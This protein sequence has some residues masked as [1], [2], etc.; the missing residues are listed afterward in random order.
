MHDPRTRTALVGLVLALPPLMVAAA[1]RGPSARAAAPPVLAVE[2][3]LVAGLAVA[4]RERVRLRAAPAGGTQKAAGTIA[5]PMA[6][7]MSGRR[8]APVGRP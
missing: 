1:P 4:A 2:A 8:R 3:V 7:R 5:V 6:L